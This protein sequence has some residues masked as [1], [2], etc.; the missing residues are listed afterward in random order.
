MCV[1]LWYCGIVCGM[2]NTVEWAQGTVVGCVAPAQR[3]DDT[4]MTDTVQYGEYNTAG[5]VRVS[6]TD[7]GKGLTSEEIRRLLNGGTV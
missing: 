4:H 1:V 6:V 7:T 3:V 2:W 5:V